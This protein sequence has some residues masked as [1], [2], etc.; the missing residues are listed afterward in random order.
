MNQNLSRRHFLQGSSAA[1]AGALL[2]PGR[3]RTAPRPAASTA[4]LVTGAT[5]APQAYGLTSWLQ[6]AKKLDSYIGLPLATTIQKVYMTEGQYYTDPLPGHITSL[7]RA[8]CQF[9]ICVFPSRSTDESAQLATFLQLL[10]S[11]GIVYEAALVNEWNSKN[12][13]VNPQDYLDYWSHYA[14]VVQAAGVPLCCLVCATSNPT[15]YAKIEPGFPTSPLPDR[16]WI[17]YYAT[18]YQYHLRLDRSGGLLDQASSEGVPAGIAE[19]G[20]GANGTAPMSVWDEF[21]PY[22]AGLAPRLPLGCLYWGSV[23][24]STQN[25]VTGSSDPKVP[26]I[27]QVIGAF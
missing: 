6:A 15:N 26:G 1:V 11:N 25:V 22:L 18:A 9:I 23:N 12:K 8:G 20:I 13:F 4:S 21:C 16:Y 24:H 5:V 14:P 10:N 27:Q 19:F 17:D 2:I 3:S 7:A